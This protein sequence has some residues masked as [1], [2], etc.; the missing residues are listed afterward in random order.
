MAKR[1]IT[2]G[3]LKNTTLANIFIFILERKQTTRREIES[4]TGFSWGTVSSH[5]TFLIEKGYVTEE[6]SEQSNVGRATYLLKPNAMHTVSI[7][8]DINRSGLSC[9]VVGLD[10]TVKKKFEAEFC[11]KTQSEVIGQ[12]EAWITMT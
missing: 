10:S 7:G 2:Q 1:Y 4:E 8:L 5:V 3:T 9:E 6:K 12:A 11:A